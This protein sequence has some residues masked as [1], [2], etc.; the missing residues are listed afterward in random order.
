MEA[1]WHIELLGGLRAIHPDRVIARFRTHKT[2][3]LLAYLAYYADRP[4]S[5]KKLIKRYWPE[6]GPE[7]GSVNF[8]K[9]LSS[10]RH[11][12][13]P[14][15]VP[16]GSVIIADRKSVRLSPAAVSTDVARFEAALH[17]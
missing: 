6:V 1:L 17:A 4:H 10:L 8:R 15:G 5:R 11:Q 12:L 16:R 7:A 3:A 9:A 13:E 14:P 2:A